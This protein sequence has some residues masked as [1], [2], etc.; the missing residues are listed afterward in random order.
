MVS[1]LGAT[2]YFQE[3]RGNCSRVPGRLICVQGKTNK[4]GSNGKPDN[5]VEDTAM[6]QA[7][8]DE[9]LTRMIATRME[10]GDIRI[11]LQGKAQQDLR[12]DELGVSGEAR[13]RETRQEV[14]DPDDRAL[15]VLD[16]PFSCT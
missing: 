12:S 15:M 8:A 11:T 10:G 16:V 13:E 4:A 7:P 6:V 2:E 14:W 9:G 3:E 5:Q 1:I